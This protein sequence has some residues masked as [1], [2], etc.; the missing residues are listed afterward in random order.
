[1]I[2][3]D[4]GNTTASFYENGI[5]KKLSLNEIKRFK[6]KEK[7]FY[8]SVNDKI[9]Q[10]LDHNFFIDLEPFAKFETLYEGLGIDRIMACYTI[11]TGIVI[12]A[13]S[14]I[15]IDFML[16]GSHLGGCILPGL[17]ASLESYKNI[18]SRLDK[19][20]NSQINIENLPQNTRDGI[21]FGIIKPLILTI[22]SIAKGRQIFLTG[23]DG[24]FLEKFLENSIYEKGLVFSGMKKLIKDN[25][26]K[27]LNI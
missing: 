15:T 13:G 6:A 24:A 21:S 3:C 16:S 25:E 12:D 19:L 8:I 27:L 4:I 23:G 17:A 9:S 22:N 20:L 11:Q 1:M 10:I 5:I 14:A 18:S 26:Q 2:L 7:I